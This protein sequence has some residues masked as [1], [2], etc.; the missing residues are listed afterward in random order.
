LFFFFFPPG[1]DTPCW[2]CLTGFLLLWGEITG[3]FKA[4]NFICT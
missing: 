2:L 4:L 1:L 3:W